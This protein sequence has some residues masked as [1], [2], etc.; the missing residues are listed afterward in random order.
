MRLIFMGTPEFA[1]P[2]LQALIGSRHEVVGVY[3]QP[4]KEQGRGKKLVFSPVKECALAAGV[5][6]FQPK[7]FKKASVIE[8][9]KSLQADA[10]V[11]AAYGKILRSSVLDMTKYGCFNV[12]A[13]LLPSYR[14]AAPINWAILNGEKETG[15]TVMQM[16]EGLDT[17]DM[18]YKEIIPV[19]ADDTGD[20]LTQKLSALGGPMILKVLDDAE[21]GMLKPEKQPE[22]SPTPYAAMLQKE[23]GELDFRK[24]P[25]ELERTIRGLYS[26]P[27]AYTYLDGK[28]LKIFRAQCVP[29]DPEAAPGTVLEI[30]KKYFTVNASGGALKILDLQLEG[31]K[32]MET[33]AFLRGYRLTAGTVLGEKADV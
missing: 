1:V 14:G 18:L 12:H 6:V 11:V 16:N 2:T 13:S 29:G 33:D 26:W 24:T 17:G 31:K 23:M 28:M 27:S 10:I 32:R 20:S 7:G 22:E 21:N 25:E 15:V 3:T 9:M 30:T 8:E 4:D 19:E 5:P